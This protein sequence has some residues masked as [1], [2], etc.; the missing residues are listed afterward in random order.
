[1]KPLL[2]FFILLLLLANISPAQVG[3][4]VDGTAPDSSAMLDVNSANK[5]VLLPRMSY[6]GLLAIINPAPG[7]MVFC[8]DCGDTGLGAMAIFINGSWNL[9][10]TN[11]LIPVAP[12]AGTHVPSS[13]QIVWHWNTVPG[14]TGYKWFTTND[15]ASAYELENNTY[16]ILPGLTCGTS[17][18]NYAWA[19][20]DCGHSS[21]VEMTQSTIACA[22][23]P[24]AITID[25]VA[26]TIAP[27]TKTVTYDIVANI[28]GEP[29][30]CWITS[31][32]GADH[33]ATFR[34]DA[35][36]ASA[37][38]YWQFNHK[39]GYKHDGATVSPSW[40]MT[41][42]IENSEWTAANDPCTLEL[43]AGWRIPTVTEW[44]NVDAG[45]YWGNWNGPWSSYLKLHAAGYLNNSNG[46]LVL[47]GSYGA[48]WSSW[49]PG[50]EVGSALYFDESFCYTRS[51]GKA[52]GFTLRC[53][54][55]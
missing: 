38:W 55:E 41:S 34:S 26:G 40:T 48:Y 33:Q 20:N 1:M 32:L 11:C 44:D 10:N 29:L 25:H 23:C 53:L 6:S 5:G 17:Y 19:Y 22:V 12:V 2:P 30:K 27:V 3:I 47:R 21:P 7:L 18:T 24:A 4:N 42:I 9:I 35:T 45:G 39:Q 28:P 8:N 16:M 31:N 54:S 46:A 37:G 13:T 52:Y 14:A 50:P 51:Y 49:Q 15:Y 43:G 36:E